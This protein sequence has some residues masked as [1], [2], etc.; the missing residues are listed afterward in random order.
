MAAETTEEASAMKRKKRL[1]IRLVALGL[2]A[3]AV[4]APAA[5]AMPD[6]LNGVE[7]RSL[8]D[9]RNQIV[10]PDDRGLGLRAE[11]AAPVQAAFVVG[12]DDRSLNRASNVQKATPPVASDSD[13][14]EVGTVALSGIV[15]LLAAGGMTALAIH[16]K[17]KGKLANA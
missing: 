6:G 10:S 2:A 9:S 12:P 14:L 3:A 8:Q 5:T 13:G 17:D 1:T 7:A 11:Q 4:A 15:L 16:Q